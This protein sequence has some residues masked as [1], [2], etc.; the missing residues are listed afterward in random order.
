MTS[1]M[2]IS[3][4]FKYLYL[5]VFEIILPPLWC[6]ALF[7]SGVWEHFNSF[8]KNNLYLGCVRLTPFHLFQDKNKTSKF[9]P[10]SQNNQISS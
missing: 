4:L 6:L 2:N 1:F 8:L 9:S 7:P 5:I 10:D 3:M